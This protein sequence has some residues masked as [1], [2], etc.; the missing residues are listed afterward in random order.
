LP[1]GLSI[2][3]AFAKC[4]L[5]LEGT[6]T[7]ED[8]AF[9]LPTF[10]HLLTIRNSCGS[11]DA[12]DQSLREWD[13]CF[14]TFSRASLLARVS[15]GELADD[16]GELFSPLCRSH[17][18]SEGVTSDSFDEYIK[19]VIQKHLVDGSAAAMS[20]VR[21]GFEFVLG[22]EA[23]S[24]LTPQSL[25]AGLRGDADLK[26]LKR[27]MRFTETGTRGLHYSRTTASLY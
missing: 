3:P 8:L 25:T 14:R 26:H 19:L 12:L 18:A 23:R 6:L 15:G 16:D 4:V 24:K 1:C 20:M 27:V 2:T 10:E 17:S 13:I 11:E 21:T 9:E 7:L 22:A 5:R